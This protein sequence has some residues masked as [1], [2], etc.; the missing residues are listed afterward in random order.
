MIRQV[1][2]RTGELVPFDRTKIEE[3]ARR[4]V[5]ECL[6]AGQTVSDA[7]GA[8]LEQL[9]GTDSAVAMVAD[10]V[11]SRTGDEEAPS[12]EAIQDAVVDALGGLGLPEVADAYSRYRDRRARVRAEMRVRYRASSGQSVTDQFMLVDE[13]SD[14]AHGVGGWSRDRLA[15][16]LEQSLGL[17]HD[18]AREVAKETEDRLVAM[19]GGVVSEG[20]VREMANSI[21]ADRGVSG[22]LQDTAVYTV[23]REYVRGL[24]GSKVCENSNVVANNPEAVSLSVSDMVLKQFALDSIFSQDVREAYHSGRIYL[25]DLGFPHRLYAFSPDTVVHI[26]YGQGYEADMSLDQLWR[27]F[28][29]YGTLTRMNED[30]CMGLPNQPVS[31]RRGSEYVPVE[32][33]VLSHGPKPSVRIASEAGDLEVTE[34]HA[35]LVKRGDHFMLVRSDEL[36]FDDMLVCR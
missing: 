11:M 13:A 12:V 18:E 26:M 9:G 6:Q 33:F 24:M 21:L 16:T 36:R 22:R 19:G 15:A 14:A 28:G 31:I 7:V 23:P 29:D 27:T 25:H 2:K 5:D 1:A 4:A 3:A 17:G 20:M 30:Q 8:R 34:D 32:R 35:V 10:T